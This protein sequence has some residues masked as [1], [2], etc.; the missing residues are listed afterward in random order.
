MSRLI[1]LLSERD[2]S[3]T[4]TQVAGLKFQKFSN[5]INLMRVLMM[6]ETLDDFKAFPTKAKFEL[7][8]ADKSDNIT[9]DAITTLTRL[10]T[11]IV[12]GLKKGL[13]QKD[14]KLLKEKFYKKFFPV[15]MNGLNINLS[16][17]KLATTFAKSKHGEINKSQAGI[18]LRLVK[19]IKADEKIELTAKDKVELMKMKDSFTDD[20]EE[21]PEI[22]GSVEQPTQEPETFEPSQIESDAKTKAVAS[23]EK[24]FEGKTAEE[25][26]HKVLEFDA[27]E[28]SMTKGKDLKVAEQEALEQ[29][30]DLNVVD[31]P[32]YTEAKFNFSKRNPILSQKI[33]ET[34][35]RLNQQLSNNVFSQDIKA[36][37]KIK[38]VITTMV[39]DVVDSMSSHTP[40]FIGS[41]DLQP[42]I[43][44]NG[45]E[46]M[47]DMIDPNKSEDDFKFTRT[48]KLGADGGIDSVKHEYFVLPPESQ[49][50]GISKETI[51]DS[52][53]AYKAAGINKINLHANIGMGGYV[54]LRYGFRPSPEQLENISAGFIDIAKSVKFGL[55][56]QGAMVGVSADDAADGLVKQFAGTGLDTYILDIKSK[57]FGLPEK[58][59]QLEEE[60]GFDPDNYEKIEF[61]SSF[62]EVIGDEM[63]KIGT[64]LSKSFEVNPETISDDISLK[65]FDVKIGKKV[66]MELD[67][68]SK[69]KSLPPRMHQQEADRIAKV[70]KS[71]IDPSIKVTKKGK[72][73]WSIESST[74]KAKI[75]VKK[76]MT[77][78]GINVGDNNDKQAFPA[79]NDVTGEV[80][81]MNWKGSLDLNDSKQYNKALEYATIK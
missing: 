16:S 72:A 81:S 56:G 45:N 57:F 66:A 46:I 32:T 52:L 21:Q 7:I 38:K 48:L 33:L 1:D 60:L 22:P 55:K 68:S 73:T 28:E 11:P 15:L 79:G 80:W 76:W 24:K 50:T 39:A 65:S 67:F 30:F 8:L 20:N 4:Y 41:S 26:Q 25:I 9:K 49:G 47:I 3:G 44:I 37:S 69:L 17:L 61:D 70:L 18:I 5:K 64:Q 59:K 71:E 51:A 62:N 6:I 58:I 74:T 31:L 29:E 54:W 35:D 75:T 34:K 14:L 13:K 36:D 10:Y 42:E 23:L 77:I 27:E 19:S 53:R 63:L 43:Y 78:T 40:E 12:T 2:T